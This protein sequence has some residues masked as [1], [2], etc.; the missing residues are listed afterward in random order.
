L[1]PAALAGLALLMA[2]SPSHAGILGPDSG[3]TTASNVPGTIQGSV[4]FAV[5]Q[6]QGSPT[7]D[8]FGTNYK[9]SKGKQNLDTKDF[10]GFNVNSA[11]TGASA[12]AGLDAS[13]KYLYMY[14][15]T[16]N[17]MT[18]NR[19][20][21]TSTFIPVNPSL[22]TSYGILRDSTTSGVKPLG[23][24]DNRGSITGLNKPSGSSF[25]NNL[26]PEMLTAS[27][28]II[29]F[30][31][32]AGDNLIGGNVKTYA[33]GEI[34]K[35]GGP[36]KTLDLQSGGLMVT[37]AGAGITA[38]NRGD[39]FFFTSN[40]APRFV[41]ADLNNGA[42]ASATGLVVTPMPAPASVVLC[43]VGIAVVGAVA[44]LRRW[45]ATRIQALPA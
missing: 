30:Q 28:Q 24:T 15:V 26:G 2:C 20:P 37:W 31:Y 23:F 25:A 33:P 8:V 44:G 18:T 16:N 14:Q 27:G 41:F 10:T 34:D 3:N 43:G 36:F 35:D 29:G 22:V 12:A 6:N 19:L 39:I 32:N 13:A 45:R 21:I 1:L 40:L 5:Y 42:N 11:G 4:N 17:G 9:D 7:L 38:G